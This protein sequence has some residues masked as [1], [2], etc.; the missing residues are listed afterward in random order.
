MKHFKL[1]LQGRDPNSQVL[2]YKIICEEKTIVSNC[3]YQEGYTY[4]AKLMSPED[5]FQE[6]ENTEKSRIL[7]Y[8]E[9]MDGHWLMNWDEIHKRND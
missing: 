2:L 9:L 5:T 7:T 6:V 1:V 8:S 4:L 3:M